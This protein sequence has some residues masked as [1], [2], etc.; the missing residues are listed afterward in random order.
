MKNKTLKSKIGSGS[1]QLP[2]TK[3]KYFVIYGG[4]YYDKPVGISGIKLEK[5]IQRECLIDFPIVDFSVPEKHELDVV[6]S[7]TLDIISSGEPLYV[8]CIAGRGRTGLFLSILA[9]C[10]GIKN[11]VEY[12]RKNYYSHAVENDEQYEFVVNY[13]P[14]VAVKFKVAVAKIVGWATP[15]QGSHTKLPNIY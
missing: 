8:G 7:S 2:L 6:L 15:P 14:T 5:N 1:L 12:V 11:P 4:S 9:K 10:F 3:N 13:K